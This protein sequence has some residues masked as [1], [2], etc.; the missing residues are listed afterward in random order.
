MPTYAYRIP[1]P[2]ADFVAAIR[3]KEMAP[4]ARHFEQIQGLHEA[5]AGD[6]AS[7]GPAVAEGLLR[8]EVQPFQVVSDA[9][10]PT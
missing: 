4:M 6:L 3:P 5:A 2:R 9:P 1:P 10:A 8:L 7:S